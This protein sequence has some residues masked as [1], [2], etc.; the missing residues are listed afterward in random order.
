MKTVDV[1]I[2]VYKPGA[3]FRKLLYRL[4]HQ[5][6]PIKTI[7]MINTEIEFFEDDLLSAPRQAGIPVVVQHITK[8]EYD[9]AAT[10]HRMA[11]ESDADLLLFMTQDAFP[12]DDQLI[13]RLAEAFEDEAVSS[14]YARQLPKPGCAALE[15]QSRRFNY[16]AVSSKKSAEDRSRLGIKTYFCSNVCA[17]YRKSVYEALGGFDGGAIFN[18][19]MIFAKKVIEAGYS[20]AY[21]AD[22]RVFHSHNYTIPQYFRRSFDMA[23]S[24]AQ[25]PEV[26][27]GVSSEKEGMRLV[28]TVAS[29][30]VRQGRARQLLPF[31]LQCAAKYAGYFLGKHYEKLPAKVV[32][33]CTDNKSFWKKA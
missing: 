1:C 7:R 20:I 5:S 19:D 18:E 26:F 22:A 29:E 16:P 10:R 3:E 11:L 14:A 28:R 15:K 8:D 17:M 13:R 21:V 30:L 6:Y 25:H 24:Q 31:G 32:L 27:K 33:Y 2:P 12:Q 23:V 9:H 4:C